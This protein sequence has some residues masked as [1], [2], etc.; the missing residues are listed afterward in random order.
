VLLPRMRNAAPA[1]L[2][3]LLASSKSLRQQL[4][5]HP[6][7][8]LVHT[9]NA[10]RPAPKDSELNP[11]MALSPEE[12][13]QLY[14]SIR[15][16]DVVHGDP[17]AGAVGERHGL[18]WAD[19]LHH[20]LVPYSDLVERL[21]VLVFL[22][23]KNDTRRLTGHVEVTLQPCFCHVAHNAL[24][25]VAFCWIGN[26]TREHADEI[27][28]APRETTTRN[29]VQVDG[30]RF[31]E[32]VRDALA[33]NVALDGAFQGVLELVV[34]QRHRQCNLSCKRTW[35]EYLLH[36]WLNYVVIKKN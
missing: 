5:H 23:H 18:A 36:G 17:T 21:V 31:D 1:C 24:Q 32:P 14:Q 35:D 19:N 29:V 22:C 27:D 15:D 6:A 34:D 8:P 10:P 3:K 26:V 28:A 7:H 11:P 30:V 12:Q 9:N 13:V 2:S 16:G 25:D 20:N 4:L 33:R